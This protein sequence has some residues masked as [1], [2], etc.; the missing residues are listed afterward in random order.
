MRVKSFK[1][2]MQTAQLDK[3]DELYSVE[4]CNYIKLLN[5]GN[6]KKKASILKQIK[7]IDKIYLERKGNEIV[8]HVLFSRHGQCGQWNQKKMGLKPN[9]AIEKDAEQNMQSTNLATKELLFYPHSLQV[10]ISPMNRAMQ[11][12][13]LLIPKGI[14]NAKIIVEPALT[15]NSELPSGW[16]IRSTADLQLLTKQTSFWQAPFKKIFLKISQWLYGDEYFKNHYLQRVAAAKKIE[17]Y[18]NCILQSDNANQPDVCQ[19]INYAG[20]KIK[21]IQELIN[22]TNN[23]DAWLFGHGKNFKIFFTKVL[24]IKA[25]FAYAETRSVYKI[26]ANQSVFLYS[27][28]YVFFINQKT[29]K[30]EGKYTA[31]A[32]KTKNAEQ[33]LS[34]VPEVSGA[35]VQLGAALAQDLNQKQQEV[36]RHENLSA[37]TQQEI[38]PQRSTSLGL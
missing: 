24:G 33:V 16:D 2:L 10:A 6:D 5:E 17:A 12:A 34:D 9:T 22:N 13:S 28:P 23:Q 4:V 3:I 20:D 35:M 19:N 1:R 18:G 11:T 30:I 29:G 8:G 37:P 14:S 7:E 31:N 15:E 38:Q 32:G 36:M 21:A 27:P 26:R 25:D